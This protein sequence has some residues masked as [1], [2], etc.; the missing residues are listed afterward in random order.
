MEA[1]R[2]AG[3]IAPTGLVGIDPNNPL[4]R[5]VDI[6]AAYNIA[7]EAGAFAVVGNTDPKAPPFDLGLMPSCI[8]Q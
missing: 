1:W 6:Q 8:Q 4:I 5:V 7:H 3:A 2:R